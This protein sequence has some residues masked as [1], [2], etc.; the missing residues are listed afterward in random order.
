MM[1]PLNRVSAISLMASICPLL[2]A[3]II[4]QG[5]FTWLLKQVHRKGNCNLILERADNPA[6]RF[7]L[8]LDVLFVAERKTTLSP[9]CDISLSSFWDEIDVL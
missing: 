1:F 6:L 9:F 5:C 2:A 3:A 7:F 4:S 8:S